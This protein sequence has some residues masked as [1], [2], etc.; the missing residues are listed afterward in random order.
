M[1]ALPRGRTMARADLEALPDD[2]WRHEL[3]DGALVLTPA[4]GGRTSRRSSSS[5]SPSTPRAPPSCGSW[6]RRS[7]STSARTRSYTPISWPRHD[8]R[9][10]TP[11]STAS[12]PRHR[13]PLA[14]DHPHRPRTQEGSLRD[15]PLPVVLGRRPG[16]Q[17]ARAIDHDVAPRG[18]QVRR[19]RNRSRSGAA[20]R[21][22]AVRRADLAGRSGDVTIEVNRTGPGRR[23]RQVVERRAASKTASWRA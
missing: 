5:W 12:T 21:Q 15:R 18:R 22:P 14:V 11:D 6:W 16:L 23:H 7:R 20:H 19:D 8:P 3:V 10:P 9:S 4:P 1:T 13:G 17:R 2:G